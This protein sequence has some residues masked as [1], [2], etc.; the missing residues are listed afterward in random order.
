MRKIE[1]VV[2]VASRKDLAETGGGHNQKGVNFQRVWALT[3][4]FELEKEALFLQVVRRLMHSPGLH[5]CGS[6]S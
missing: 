5:V 2:R 1:E 3:R 4:M 6:D